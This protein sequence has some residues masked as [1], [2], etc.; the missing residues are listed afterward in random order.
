MIATGDFQNINS[1]GSRSRRIRIHHFTLDKA[2]NCKP[3]LGAKP[4]P[5]IV[6]WGYLGTLLLIATYLLNCHG[7]HGEEDEDL[8]SARRTID[9]SQRNSFAF[10][11][12]HR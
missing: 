8:F 12:A 9:L 7:C 2:Y 11:K 6:R 5:R 10:P 4:K 1:A 3:A